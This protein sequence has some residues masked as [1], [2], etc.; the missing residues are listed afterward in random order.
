VTSS[1]QTSTLALQN[2]SQVDQTVTLVVTGG[3]V[4]SNNSGGTAMSPIN[5]GPIQTLA[6]IWTSNSITV[7]AGQSSYGMFQAQCTDSN[8]GVDFGWTSGANLTRSTVIGAPPS[9]CSGTPQVCILQMTF[10][11]YQIKVSGDQGAL[12]AEIINSAHR[13]G[14]TND[15]PFSVP[16]SML[17]N[18][19]RPF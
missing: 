19:G 11:N 9:S 10:L 6:A 3:Q 12:T 5:Q 15:N 17:V 18:G 16:A 13:C 8:C 2:I 7:P 4:S 14:G 1:V